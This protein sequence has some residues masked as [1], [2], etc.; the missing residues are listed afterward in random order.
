MNPLGKLAGLCGAVVGA[1][2][3]SSATAGPPAIPRP[4][5]PASLPKCRRENL[6]RIDVPRDACFVRRRALPRLAGLVRIDLIGGDP[7]D[8]KLH[9]DRRLAVDN[10]DASEIFRAHGEIDNHV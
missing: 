1:V 4:R 7:V 9:H 5:S 2:W 8:F 10:A 6:P 3:L